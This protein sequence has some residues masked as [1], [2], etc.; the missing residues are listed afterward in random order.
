MERNYKAQIEIF[1]RTTERLGDRPTLLNAEKTQYASMNAWGSLYHC[2]IMYDNVTQQDFTQF[3]NVSKRCL[4]NLVKFVEIN[5]EEENVSHLMDRILFR[6]RAA[7]TLQYQG[8][9]ST[10]KLIEEALKKS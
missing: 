3:R 7:L 6:L 2:A 8:L 4:L 9:E 5:P 1:K 10:D